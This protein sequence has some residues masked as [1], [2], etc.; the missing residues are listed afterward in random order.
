MLFRSLLQIA[1]SYRDLDLFISDLSLEDP[2]EEE[3]NRDSVVLS[4]IHSAKGL[5]WGA[6]LLV[7]LV[8]ER[9]PSRHAI[10][11]AEDFEEERRLMYVA[12]T[13]ARDHL[14]LFVPASLYSRGD[15]GN[16]PAVPSPFVRELPAHL[17]AEMHESYSGGLTRRDVQNG[18]RGAGFGGGRSGVGGGGFAQ[19]NRFDGA[20]GIPRPPM[21]A[22]G[23]TPGRAGGGAGRPLPPTAYPGGARP[24]AQAP[25]DRDA[26]GF[27][28][29]AEGLPGVVHQH[30]GP[31]EL[32]SHLAEQVL[33]QRVVHPFEA[34]G[35]AG[36]DLLGHPPGD[37]RA[38]L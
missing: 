25:V 8:E 37:P 24:G 6:V 35:V 30:H 13:R 26:G 2:G 32:R 4:T 9:F 23:T 16:Q 17:F 5:E 38:V 21:F 10:A 19:G 31:K 14:C 12:C 22:E 20:P 34:G 28:R 29:V 7:D 15:G 3:E 36:G 1:A 11:R 33:D 18:Q 27:R